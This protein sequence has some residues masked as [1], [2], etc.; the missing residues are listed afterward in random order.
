LFGDGLHERVLT[1]LAFSGD[2]L[3]TDRPERSPFSTDT[4]NVNAIQKLLSG[5]KNI[6]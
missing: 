2:F 5:L 3:V 6:L 1:N 4:Q